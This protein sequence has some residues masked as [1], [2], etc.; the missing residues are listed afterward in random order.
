MYMCM[1]FP[2]VWEQQVRPTAMRAWFQVRGLSFGKR[3]FV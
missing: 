1:L 3:G 2:L